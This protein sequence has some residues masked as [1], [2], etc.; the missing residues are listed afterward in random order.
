MNTSSDW[1]ESIVDMDIRLE[2]K[3]VEMGKNQAIFAVQSTYPFSLSLSSIS[4]AREVTI[5][6]A[7]STR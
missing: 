3:F 5:K 6:R 1:Y 4:I 7:F 2:E